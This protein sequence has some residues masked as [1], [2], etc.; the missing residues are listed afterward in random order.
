[1]LPP[2]NLLSKEQNMSILEAISAAPHVDPR[3]KIVHTPE[4]DAARERLDA[5]AEREGL[6]MQR[7][8]ALTIRLRK[9]HLV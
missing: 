5:A 1:M 4:A 3:T 7:H 6:A 2:R 8:A 9:Y